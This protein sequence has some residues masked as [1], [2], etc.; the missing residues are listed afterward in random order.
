M[1]EYR[2]SLLNERLF[3][4]RLS[5]GGVR[6]ATLPEILAS[7]GARDELRAFTSL[8]H[9]QAHAWHI[10]LVQLA[11]LAM[12]EAGIDDP[13][14]DSDWW[15]E[16]LLSLTGGQHEPWALVVPDLGRPA[17]LQP[18]V[19]EG[20]LDGFRHAIDRPD[21]LDVLVTSKNHDVKASRI[22][23]PSPDHWI[24]A[25]MSLQ[26]TAGYSGRANYG[27]IRMKSGYGSRTVVG[28]TPELSW[29]AWFRRD[30]AV[31]L[32]ARPEMIESHAYRESGG[33]A[34]LWLEPWDGT[35]GIPIG[36]LDPFFVEVCRRVRLEIRNH[37]IRALTANSA[38][39]RITA[40]DDRGD[41]GDAW[42]PISRQD[43]AALNVTEAGF[44]YQRLQ[45]ILFGG[46]YARSPAVRI[47]PF[48]GGS[49]FLEAHAL[50]R[51]QGGT[52]GFHRRVVP[53]P[54]AIRVKLGRDEDRDR[55][56]RLAQERVE[57]AA[58]AQRRVLHPAIC[59]LLQGGVEQLNLR[60]ER[61]RRWTT[62]FD[63]RVDEVFFAR[64][65]DDADLP[66]EEARE[67]WT[68]TLQELAWHALQAAIGSAPLPVARRY[69]AIA[70]AEGL[71]NGAWRKH[72][73]VQDPAEQETDR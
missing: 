40:P 67:R 59:A 43:G 30:L 49:L 31:L 57:L 48:D 64:L 55:L 11:A 69:R 22:A 18:P 42:T 20:T 17:F 7:L 73:G 9:H 60:D 53:V 46:D 4:I 44:T 66:P 15:A 33:L 28:F 58:L 50:A 32:S 23:E 47:Q 39:R 10:F 56:G 14:Q 65:W 37:R 45:Q 61:T 63:R 12:H 71:F 52:A 62:R 70:R 24:Y 27:I 19:P 6:A 68:E 25:L 21:E 3:N 2:H 51:G 54:P 5:S 13:Q 38:T 36:D 34:L 16:Y 72:I 1:T 41:T 26:T 8:Q 35:S 29:G